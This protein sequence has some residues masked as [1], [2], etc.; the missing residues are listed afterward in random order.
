M[1]AYATIG[2]TVP[3]HG[4]CPLRRWGRKVTTN[5]HGWIRSSFCEATTCVEV[6]VRDDVVLVRDSK[7]P[8]VPA[9]TYTP[10]EWA[11]FIAGVRAGEFDLEPDETTAAAL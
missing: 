7:R 6:S 11:A 8:E 10:E 4:D 2:C 5:D 9:L 3:P 1:V